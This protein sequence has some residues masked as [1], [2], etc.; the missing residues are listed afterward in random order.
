M[1]KNPSNSTV[2][3]ALFLQIFLVY[4]H[5]I[6][7]WILEWIM[8]HGGFSQQGERSKS[9]YKSGLVEKSITIIIIWITIHPTLVPTQLLVNFLHHSCCGV[10]HSK[11]HEN[12]SPHNKNI[13]LASSAFVAKQKCQWRNGQSTQLYPCFVRYNEEAIQTNPQ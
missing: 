5:C 1:E 13:Q 9:W 7:N 4:K 11:W 3:Y 10:Y 12:I 6:T 8:T 2:Y